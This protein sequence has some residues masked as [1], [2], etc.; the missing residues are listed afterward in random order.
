MNIRLSVSAESV[1]HSA[2]FFSNNKSANTAFNHSFSPKSKQ[3]IQHG[4]INQFVYINVWHLMLGITCT[5]FSI[6]EEDKL[7]SL[8]H[9]C[10]ILG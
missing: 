3:M 4:D 2:V 5:T 7:P 8:V 1:S 9:T 6:Y 10:C